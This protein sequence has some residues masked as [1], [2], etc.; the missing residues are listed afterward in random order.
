MGGQ[1]TGQTA[2]GTRDGAHAAGGRSFVLN[3]GAMLLLAVIWG[4]SIPVTK[5]GLSSTTP[6]VLTALRF[7][8]AVPVLFVLVLGR[9]IPPLGAMP[10]LAGLGLLGIGIGQVAQAF[11]VEGTSASVGTI[12]SA[13]IP[14]FIVVFAAQRLKQSVTGRQ[15]LGLLAAFVGI[16]VVALGNDPDAAAMSS[17]TSV[18]GVVWLLLSAVTIAFYYVWSIELTRFHGAAVV[19]AWSTLFGLL[20]LLP[21]VAL[22]WWHVP[23][24]ITAEALAVAA[25]LGLCVTAAGLF[26]W[27]YVARSVPARISASVQYLQ[28]VIGIAAAAAIFGDRLGPAFAGGVA[29]IMVGLGLAVATQRKPEDAVPHE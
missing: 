29:L 12:I 15:Q 13:T 5:L 26:L 7:V 17:R 20:S 14:V 11:G 23:A 3:L 16:A 10:R 18:A 19:S 27:L 21:F 24:S 9:P 25:Y 1:V 22:E 2:A 28:P 6:L 8:V 4:L